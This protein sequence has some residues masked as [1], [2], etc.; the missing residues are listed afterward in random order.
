MRQ[1]SALD[2]QFLNV[3]S[4]TTTGHVGSLLI[5]DSSTADGEELTL[6]HV[7]DIYETRLHLAP[8]L[9]QRLVEV[10]LALGRPY[11]ADVPD[12]DLE[13]HLREIALPGE[14]TED[15]LGEQI[16]R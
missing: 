8:V 4:S 2:A 6:E 3:E 16:S 7:R 1:L 10:P 15:Q 12:F 13:F 11:W 14:G 5:L 9:R